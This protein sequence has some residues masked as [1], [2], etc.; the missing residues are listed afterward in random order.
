MK[1]TMLFVWAICLLAS[2]TF[3]QSKVPANSKVY[4]SKMEGGLDGFIAT[5]ILKKKLP[6]T[7]V[8][9]DKDADFILVGTS[10]KADDKWYH[11]VFGGKDKNEGNV[12]LL[13]VKDKTLV[14]AGEAGDRS[15]MW[16]SL[17]RGGQRKV[18]D[19]I[20]SK[21]KKDLFEKKG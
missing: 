21:M 9:E 18:A 17:R 16:G 5:E 8:T 12:Q 2:L 15:L 7:I 3:A 6:I 14:W 13:S 10:I 20:V 19:R 11:T 1:R 4:I